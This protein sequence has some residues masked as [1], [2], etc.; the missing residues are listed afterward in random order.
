MGAYLTYFLRA[1]PEIRDLEHVPY[2]FA[3]QNPNLPDYHGVHA[4]RLIAAIDNYG[5]GLEVARTPETMVSRDGSTQFF[6][7]VVFNIAEEEQLFVRSADRRI[8]NVYFVLKKTGVVSH[9]VGLMSHTALMALLQT[10]DSI[11]QYGCVFWRGD[12]GDA[13]A[14]PEDE[15]ERLS[16]TTNIGA[17]SVQRTPT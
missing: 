11:Y 12:L 17:W 6:Y 15:V 4:T 5:R 14:V 1:D 16:A 13:A 2:H 9:R 7:P 10:D 8:V 3:G